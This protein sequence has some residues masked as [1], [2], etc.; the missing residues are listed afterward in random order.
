VVAGTGG[1]ASGVQ[2][3]EGV[4]GTVPRLAAASGAVVQVGD[5]PMAPGHWGVYEPRTN[6]VYV[7][8][9]AFVDGARLHYVVAHE[10]AHAYWFQVATGT[11][12]V[13]FGAAVAGGPSVRGGAGELFADCVASLW[14]ATTSYYWT[15]PPPARDAVAAAIA[16]AVTA[17]MTVP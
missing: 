7:S 1:S 12:R 16:S 11:Q 10:L 9:A 13:A 17:P 4:L 6:V 14:G 8:G 15:C 3:V 5:A 2:Q